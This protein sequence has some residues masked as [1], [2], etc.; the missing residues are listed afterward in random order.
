MSS[1]EGKL[2]EPKK[3]VVPT[4]GRLVER[5][6]DRL[7]LIWSMVRPPHRRCP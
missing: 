5:I 4:W 1:Q 6:T 3:G 7:K 2:E